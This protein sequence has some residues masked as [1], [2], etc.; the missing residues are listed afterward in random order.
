MSQVGC[1]PLVCKCFVPGRAWYCFVCIFLMSVL[2]LYLYF[3]VRIM[4]VRVRLLW[5]PHA[6]MHTHCPHA[7]YRALVLRACA[8]MVLFV[9]C[10]L[11]VCFLF[12]FFLMNFFC[13]FVRYMHAQ[14]VY[15]HVCSRD[16]AHT[17][18]HTRIPTT[19]TTTMTLFLDNPPPG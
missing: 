13:L 6:C 19:T 5:W 14:R 12:R 16:H 11:C 15:V 17:H 10:I 18:K 2:F 4:I 7:R 1:T 3:C 8:R 9:F